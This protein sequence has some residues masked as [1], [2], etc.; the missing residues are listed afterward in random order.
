LER[1]VVLES[2]GQQM[3]GMLHLPQGKGPFPAVAIYHGFT[4]TKVEPHRL[5]VKMARALM[6]AGIAAVRFD[7]RGSGDSE[8]D[9]ADMTVSGEIA[10][11]IRVLDFLEEHEAVD[12]QRL[13][14][15]GL[16]M[17]GAVAASVAGKDTRVKSLALWAAVAKFDVFET[18]EELLAQARK[19]GWVDL[20]GNMLK[21]SFYED[22]R[23]QK[24]LDWARR[25]SGTALIVHG[26]A[27]P[28]VPV[29]HADLYYDALAG[30]K[31]KFIVPGADHTFNSQKWETAVIEKTA[32]WFGDT[33]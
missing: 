12:A 10:D 22:A 15:L 32:A 31:E 28:T 11:A 13:G 18:E 29:A 14:V 23:Q 33:L 17:G 9:F 26:D 4:G 25:F 16:S 8:G 6:A 27:D 7:F 24:P 3:V 21:Y 30:T 19:Q 5:F 20:N 1:P 2:H